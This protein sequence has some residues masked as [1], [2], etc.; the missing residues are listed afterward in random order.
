[1]LE[2]HSIIHRPPGF[3][4]VSRIGSDSPLEFGISGQD[5]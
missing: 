5:F 2:H 3:A 1:M 4:L